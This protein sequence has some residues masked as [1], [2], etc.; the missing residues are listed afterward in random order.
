[1][2]DEDELDSMQ[3]ILVLLRKTREEI[4]KLWNN[5]GSDFAYFNVNIDL[6]VK[7]DEVEV[8]IKDGWRKMS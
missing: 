3:K 6:K 1:M 2:L 7:V 5:S 4:D 8:R